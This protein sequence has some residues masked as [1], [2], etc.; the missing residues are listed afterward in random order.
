MCEI[1]KKLSAITFLVSWLCTASTTSIAQG[2]ENL[3]FKHYSIEQG[4]SQSV[5]MCVLQDDKGFIWIGTQEGLNRF[6]GYSFKVF[7]HDP[8]DTSSLSADYV[9]SILQDKQKRI[10]IGTT[11]G[12]NLF[13]PETETFT[14][15]VYNPKIAS[16]LSNNEVRA[17]YQ[18]RQGRLWVGTGFGLNLYDEKK[19]TFTHFLYNPVDLNSLSDNRVRGIYQDRQD[20]MWV[21]TLGG[22]NRM[23]GQGS[24]T[25]FVHNPKEPNSLSNN[26]VYDILQDNQNRMWIATRGGG[27]NLLD[28]ETSQFTHLK[29]DPKDPQ[30]LSDDE[31]LALLMDVH[32]QVWMGTTNGLNI[33]NPLTLKLRSYKHN[34]ADPSSLSNSDIRDIIQD[35]TGNIWIGTLGGGL[36]FIDLSSQVFAH[37]YHD[38][39]NPASI[40]DNGAW[41][42]YEDRSGGVWIGTGNGLNVLVPGSSSFTRFFHDPG[43]PSSLSHSSVTV[44]FQDRDDRMWVGTRNGL[45]LLD[46]DRKKFR[47]FLSDPS[48]PS[49]ISG[50]HLM[51]V[52]QDH[53]GNYWVGTIDHGLNLFDP[54]TE[55]FLHFKYDPLNP[56]SLGNNHI[57]DILQDHTG[58]I[59]VG[60]GGGL[61]LFDPAKGIFKRYEHDPDNL[62][63]LSHN[64]VYDIFQDSKNRLWVATPGGLNLFYPEK[65]VFTAWQKKDGL[66]NDAVYGILE[67]DNGNL[68]MS[69]NNGLNKFNPETGKFTWYDKQDGLQDNEF[70]Q[71]SFL[72]DH[73][74]K[75]YFGGFNGVSVFHPDSIKDNTYIPPVVITGFQ[76]FNK[77]V[78][79]SD[80]TVL[81]NSLSHTREITLANQQNVFA[82]EFSALN[83]RQPEKN[84]FAYKLEPFNK[85]WIYTDFKDR[86]AVFTNIPPGEYVFRVKASNDDGY[87]NEEGTNIKVVILP[88][89]WLTIWAKILWAG[90]AIGIP[91][92]FYKIRTRDLKAQRKK[93]QEQVAEQTN[94]LHKRL[95]EKKILYELSSNLIGR[96]GLDEVLKSII[97]AG[98]TIVPNAQSSSIFLLNQN[99]NVLEGKISHRLPSEQFKKIK[100]R[101]GEGLSG[102]ALLENNGFIENFVKDDLLFTR[103]LENDVTRPLKSIIV[104]LLKNKD[105][106]IGTISV[107]NYDQHEAFTQDD[108][109]ALT[110]LAA[111]ASLAIER[112]RMSN[113]IEDQVDIIKESE[114]KLKQ[115]ESKLKQAFKLA[116]I[117]SWE[118]DMITKELILNPEF[119]D[120][121][122]IQ[123]KSETRLHINTYLADFI[124]PEDAELV[125]NAY[126]LFFN[127][128]ASAVYNP[129]SYRIIRPDKTVIWGI[130]SPSSVI[131]DGDKI[132]S[133]YGL[134]QDIT[135]LKKI[136]QDLIRSSDELKKYAED[137]KI[138]NEELNATIE[139]LNTANENLNKAYNQLKELDQYKESMTAMIVHDFKNSLNT[140]I[141]FSEGTPTERRLRSIRQAGQFMLNMVMNILDLQK[142]ES[143]S[144]KLSLANY[145]VDKLVHEAVDQLSYLMEQ[146]AIKLNYAPTGQ[147]YCR[148]DHDLTVRVIV[149]ILSNAIKYVPQ[150]GKI[151]IL[152]ARQN[153][154]VQVAIRDNGIGIPADKL[155]LVFEKYVQINAQKSGSVRSTGIGLTFSK[156]VVENLGGTIGVESVEGK[157]STFYF[158]LPFV[159]E[160]LSDV[161]PI[162]HAALLNEQDVVLNEEEQTTLKPWLEKLQQWEVYDYSEVSAIIEKIEHGNS[163]IASWKEQLTKAL[164]TGNE[165]KFNKLLNK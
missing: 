109:N 125:S 128:S 99:E 22:L 131:R 112:V 64:T 48:N 117:A 42:I 150:N 134:F 76:L 97:D 36:N 107:D 50:N 103:K 70:S 105:Q 84:R 69:T 12:L 140:V 78:A 51:S 142:F 45:N 110:S 92:T 165:G 27:I 154:F 129:I 118:V 4:L 98:V 57:N 130:G 135:A 73:E 20:R 95:K 133:V 15:F 7:K 39:Q 139:E 59:W 108:F 53:Q 152:V 56:E 115:N 38:P 18:D 157:G 138:S 104:V 124:H 137:L 47:H 23:N 13:N 132:I 100:F 94:E 74:G 81:K 35:H 44:I 43:N 147:L 106:T 102:K 58:R 52:Y 67:D 72:K 71:W 126:Q 114:K 122:G 123:N 54:E 88:P 37:F 85:D 96:L 60:T 158:T 16:S 86:K 101:V 151:D 49:S 29:H 25:R 146:K 120:I 31:V 93:L 80:T 32:D 149:N 6:D 33:I 141:S 21:G 8:R 87:W 11:G 65:G 46:P 163:N 55:K 10:W 14:R 144:V 113:E 63:S 26:I 162:A 155:H 111:N 75:M 159:N 90:V 160:D 9:Y 143:A 83:Y 17:V 2:A 30:S 61:N 77:P 66:S 68:W 121:L 127:S 19:K 82:F 34:P 3:K 145:T 62:S 164:Q 40:S 91:I 24:F 89:W 161:Q 5:A 136:E 153:E 119:S 28:V 116:R 79:V 156:I 148:V 41:G 1:I